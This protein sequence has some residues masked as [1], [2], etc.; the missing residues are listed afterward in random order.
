MATKLTERIDQLQKLAFAATTGRLDQVF[1][2]A[3]K[4]LEVLLD[5]KIGSLQLFNEVKQQL[6]FHAALKREE[7]PKLQEETFSLDAER[8]SNFVFKTGEPLFLDDSW[9]DPKWGEIQQRYHQ[10]K[11]LENRSFLCVPLKA[12][13]R[14]LGVLNV[15]DGAPNKF[16]EEDKKISTLLASLIAVAIQNST[17][18][19]K[20]LET[21]R[22]QQNIEHAIHMANTT[23]MLSHSLTNEV[24]FIHQTIDMIK[25]SHEEETLD[26]KYLLKMLSEMKE[27]VMATSEMLEK[28]RRA[29]QITKSEYID[30]DKCIS[31]AIQGLPPPVKWDITRENMPTEIIPGSDR[32]VYATPGLLEEVFKNLLLNSWEAMQNFLGEEKKVFI[33]YRQISPEYIEVKFTDTGPGIPSKIKRRLFNPGITTKKKGLG[34][35]GLWTVREN[36]HKMGGDIRLEELFEP[37]ARFILTLPLQPLDI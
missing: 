11:G 15:L 20:L 2:E 3:M 34:G 12:Q 22:R 10:E 14:T 13:G 25:S 8:I 9:Q 31:Q 7:L 36:L 1:D 27:S 29:E 37:G 17:D 21:Q 18:V 4:A 16:S 35:I 6:E 28:I 5:A 32:P 19:D 24:G 30:L 26:D 33:A 23:N